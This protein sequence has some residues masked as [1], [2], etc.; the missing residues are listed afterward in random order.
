MSTA[1]IFG[2]F[3]PFHGGHKYLFEQSRQLAPRLLV[4]VTSDARLRAQ[5]DREPYQDQDTRLRHVRSQ[6]EVD[7]ALIGEDSQDSWNLLCSLSFDVLV[8]G[9]DQGP[10]DEQ[11]KDLLA[12][13]GK[14]GVRIVRLGAHKPTEYKSSYFRR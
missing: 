5:K 7:E 9:Y 3:D 10:S 4:V 14:E 2:T 12:K 13:C 6:P 1:L 11:V 8:L